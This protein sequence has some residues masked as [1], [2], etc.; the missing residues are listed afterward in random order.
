MPL[1]PVA[2][3]L[4]ATT[5][6]RKASAYS[7]F[8]GILFGVGW[9][10]WIDAAVRG[11]FVAAPDGWSTIIVSGAPIAVGSLF[12][13]V[14]NATEIDDLGQFCHSYSFGLQQGRCANLL[15]GISAVLGALA[16]ASSVG[17]LLFYG[18]WLRSPGET[19]LAAAAVAATQLVFVAA[20]I[21]WVGRSNTG[22]LI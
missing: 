16:V 15:L 21:F 18:S 11:P 4:D 12:L 9:L 22:N 17:L 8:A 1:R 6:H 7:L 5:R 14:L 19:W 20:I 3:L 10:I 13:F 2:P